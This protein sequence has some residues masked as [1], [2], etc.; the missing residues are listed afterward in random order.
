METKD[1][2][3][4][5][6][7]WTALLKKVAVHLGDRVKAGDLLAEADSTYLAGNADYYRQMILFAKANLKQIMAREMQTKKQYART[8]ELVEKGIV[9]ASTLETH[10]VA[11]VDAESST[12]GARKDIESLERAA[13]EIETNLRSANYYAAID[14]VV[15]QILVD[16]NNISGSYL[17][18]QGQTIARIDRPGVYVVTCLALDTQLRGVRAGK[19]ATVVFESTNESLPGKVVNI[20]PAPTLAKEGIPAYLVR[21]EFSKPGPLLTQGTLMRVEI[22][23]GSPVAG[24]YVPWSAVQIAAAKTTVQVASADGTWRARNVKLGLRDAER[25]E[26]KEG[27]AAGDVVKSLLW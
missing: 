13:N 18:N 2:A 26:I 15:S 19:P 1:W 24:L 3:L 23:I 27:L 6:V 21:I 7:V 12:R 17:A 25:V 20:G 22:P 4:S 16:P 9:S 10:E 8:R 11:M 14:G 5:S